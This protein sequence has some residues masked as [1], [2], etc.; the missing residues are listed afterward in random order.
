VGTGVLVGGGVF[1]A[2][3]VAAATDSSLRVVLSICALSARL[4]V[5]PG[6]RVQASSK[7][8]IRQAMA[9]V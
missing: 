3:A 2:V 6:E 5:L 4:S 7:Q 8:A 1:V 9:S